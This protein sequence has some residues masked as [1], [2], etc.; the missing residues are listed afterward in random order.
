MATEQDVR[1]VIASLPDTSEVLSAG[2]P[3]FRVGRRGFAK[4]RRDPDVLVVHTADL[5]D[6]ARLIRADPDKYFSTAHY[7]GEAA[8]LVR[9]DAVTVDELRTLVTSSWQLRATGA[10]RDSADRTGVLAEINVKERG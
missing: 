9:L 1:Q 10:L 4:L 6:K 2:V 3:Y 8:V 7:D 5:E